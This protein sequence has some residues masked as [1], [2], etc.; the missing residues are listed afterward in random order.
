ME[1]SAA[2]LQVCLVP[3][4]SGLSEIREACTRKT[5]L[6]STSLQDMLQDG[7]GLS[8]VCH[9]AAGGSEVRSLLVYTSSNTSGGFLA[10][11][12]LAAA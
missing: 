4:H 12:L 10:G 11:S 3:A 7:A 1:T 2:A 8:L 6:P 5:R 9:I